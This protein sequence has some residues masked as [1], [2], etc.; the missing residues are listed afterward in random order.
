MEENLAALEQAFISYREEIE[1]FERKSKP[2]DGLLGFGRSLR[3]D[4]C[5]DR[6][7]ERVAQAVNGICGLQP[8]PETA[9]RAVRMLISRDDFSAWPLAAQWMLRAV[10]RHS[11]PLIPFLTSAA[12]AALYSEYARRYRPWDRLPVQKDVLKA[13]KQR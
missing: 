8:T 2:M 7:D 13:L 12:S 3:N 1:A 5:H 6:F 4:S 10:E 11:I 9:E